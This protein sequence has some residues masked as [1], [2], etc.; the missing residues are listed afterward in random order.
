MKFFLLKGFIFISVY[1][2]SE[3][4]INTTTPMLY[5]ALN[6][7]SYSGLF[8]TSGSNIADSLYTNVKKKMIL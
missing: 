1:A 4:Q 8:L 5:K 6:K 7:E 2:F 3:Y